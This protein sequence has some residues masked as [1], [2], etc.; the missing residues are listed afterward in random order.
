MET[1][2]PSNSTRFW[3]NY[4]IKFLSFNS[5]ACVIIF[6]TFLFILI[7][8]LKSLFKSSLKEQNTL[9][10][11]FS[12]II[13]INLVIATFLGN[14]QKIIHSKFSLQLEDQKSILDSIEIAFYA[15]HGI[16]I[17]K[18]TVFTHMAIS[19]CS[20]ALFV[21]FFFIFSLFEITDKRCGKLNL[22]E[23][24]VFSKIVTAVLAIGGTVCAVLLE[25]DWFYNPSTFKFWLY[26]LTF[27]FQCLPIL[28]ITWI[29]YKISPI[30]EILKKIEMGQRRVQAEMLEEED[31]NY[32]ATYDEES[33]ALIMQHQV[34][35]LKIKG[36]FYLS[37][38]LFFVICV[39]AAWYF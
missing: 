3:A 20:F 25:I 31:N 21:S 15:T 39:N 33:K 11:N 26:Y 10:Y 1:I 5:V 6:L 37:C 17:P 27:M 18:S 12:V 35:S 9:F 30:E 38:M 32:Y 4:D 34:V 23:F 29:F 13:F 19:L 14:F 28:C 2:N 24:T 8:H 22:V 16:E 7:S 36:L